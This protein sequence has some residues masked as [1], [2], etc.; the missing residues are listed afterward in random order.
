MSDVPAAAARTEVLRGRG[1]GSPVLRRLPR[2]AHRAV[3]PTAVFLGLVGVL[4]AAAWAMSR[5]TYNIWAAFWIAPVLILLSVPIAHRAARVD[6]D[7]RIGRIVLLA[8]VVKVI[9]GSLLRYEV[10]FGLY[11]GS[12]DSAI[13]HRIGAQLAP[14]LRH[15]T[16]SNLGHITGTRFIEVLTGQIYA[17]TGATRVGGFMVFSWMSFLGLY[18]FY[19]A[20]R[21]AY[22][23]GDYHRYALLVF[24][25]PSLV[26]WPASIGKEGFILLALGGAALGAAQLLAGRFRGAVWL[27]LGL[28]GTA[29][30]RPHMALIVGG[31]LLVAAALGA[32]RGGPQRHRSGRGRL[33]G[34]VLVLGLLVASSTLVGATE[35]FFH[36]QKLNS[37]AAQDV[38]DETT[39][40]TGKNGSTFTTV[41]ANNPV[42]FTIATGTVL[43]RPLPFEAGSAQGVLT[44][45]ESLALLGLAC[46]SWRRLIRLPV[47]VVRRPYV[48]F[49]VAYTF[50]FVYA[51]SSVA[52]FGVLAR[53][54]V[55]LL[56]LALV[57]L[58]LRRPEVGDGDPEAGAE[59]G[60][61]LPIV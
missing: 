6:G 7:P 59:T 16:Y 11:G 49:A 52:N 31:S 3:A 18:L 38:I 47:E 50:G 12:S 10:A 36:L 46:A 45:I 13:Y 58:C 30:V 44:S 48:A 29:V 61:R 22:P 20:F 27:G 4:V 32:V 28:W 56:P 23:D 57:I 21:T 33:G 25:V 35:H 9:G 53:Q 39:R 15:G 42:G 14:Q 17:F 5:G 1:G 60:A 34:V 37:Q 54:R 19:R 8:A 24:F 40:R 55:Q 26:F 43:L 2:A 51:F 41:S